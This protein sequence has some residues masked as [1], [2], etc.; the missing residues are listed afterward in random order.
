MSGDTKR[1]GYC[2]SPSKKSWGLELELW[3][4]KKR[5]NTCEH[6]FRCGVTVLG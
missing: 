6:P 1:E 4:K 5:R 3:L 2:A